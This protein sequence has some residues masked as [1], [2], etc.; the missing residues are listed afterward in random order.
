M[1]LSRPLLLATAMLAFLVAACSQ[2]N[3]L[4]S[5]VLESQFGAPD[6]EF[7]SDV[8]VSSAHPYVYAASLYRNAEVTSSRVVLRRYNRDGS[9]VWDRRSV[10]LNYSNTHAT[11]T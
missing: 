6:N 7:V 9:L 1:N 2:P 5:S 10:P 8:A 4:K 3:D 11:P